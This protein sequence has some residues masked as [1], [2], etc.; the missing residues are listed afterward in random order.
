VHKKAAVEGYEKVKR[1]LDWMFERIVSK[2]AKSE[3]QSNYGRLIN[4]LEACK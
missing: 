1:K 2:Q 3:A 4:E